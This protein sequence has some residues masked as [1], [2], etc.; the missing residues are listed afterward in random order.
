MMPKYRILSFD[1]GGVRGVYT[2]VLLERIRRAV[3]NYLDDIHL[4]AGTSTGA[5]IALGLADGRTPATAIELY[6]ELA[7]DAFRRPFS[8]QLATLWGLIG[9]KYDNVALRR[10]LGQVFGEKTLADLGRRGRHV[11]IA[12]FDLQGQVAGQTTWKPKFFH[13]FAGDDS[14][15]QE[16]VVDVALRSAAAPTYFP[17]YG[18]YIDGGV[19]A[20]N[21]SVAALA[22][23]LDASTGGQQLADIR[24][25]SLGTGWMP[26][27]LHG[28][29]QNWG[30]LQ[31]AF[32]LVP[33]LLESSEGMADYQ[34]QR[35]LGA[36]YHRLGPTLPTRIDLDDVGQ[37]DYLIEL[38]Q[39]V[40]IGPTVA[41][42]QRHFL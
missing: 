33:I 42:V 5:L 14:D 1:G 10:I 34:C 35:I 41:W 37:M 6:R 4:Y 36:Q 30:L 23:A 8:R 25:L 3:P 27:Y 9:A 31:W 38:A 11:L 28:Q 16:K 15:G 17:V 26:R 32:P 22:Q 21:P 19:A 13:N 29:N 18:R 2:A 39:K 7:D 12:A 24:L 40:D 20:N